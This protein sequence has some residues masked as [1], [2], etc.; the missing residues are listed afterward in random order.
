MIELLFSDS[1]TAALKCAKALGSGIGGV[2]VKITMDENGNQTT[3][4]FVPEDYT[5]PVVDGS[6]EDVCGIQLWASV[7]DI[8]ILSDWEKRMRTIDDFF[9]MYNEDDILFSDDEI[10]QHCERAKALVKRLR[11]A[12][13]SGEKIRIWWSNS[14]DDTCGFYWAMAL[15]NGQGATVTAVKLPDVIKDNAGALQ[16]GATINMLTPQDFA[17]MQHLETPV[18]PA[19]QTYYATRWAQLAAENA[20]LR[21]IINGEVY[22]VSDTFY[23]FVLENSLPDTPA[24]IAF[25]I[26]TALMK[27]PKGVSDW[28]YA[29]RLQAM[30]DGGKV[31][32]LEHKKPFYGSLIQRTGIGQ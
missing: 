15:L 5:G 31:K 6:P 30:I 11:A 21:A 16:Q 22:S 18:S 26:G 10:E 25:V 32:I 17:Q 24:R 7:G 2:G 27:G 28:W 13:K 4:E 12:A 9:V 23:D 19:E 20:P 3:E 8:Q 14:P 1:G 29:N